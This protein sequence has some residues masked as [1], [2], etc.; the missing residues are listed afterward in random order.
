MG[1]ST[2]EKCA[3]GRNEPQHSLLDLVDLEGLHLSQQLVVFCMGADPKPDH[4]IP[5]NLTYRPVVLANTGRIKIN[6]QPL[7]ALF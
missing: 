6:W 2:P 3:P 7:G 1:C 5:I 4:G